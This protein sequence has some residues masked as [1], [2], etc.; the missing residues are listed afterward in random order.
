MAFGCSD[1]SSGTGGSGG[2]GGDGGGGDGGGGGG[3]DPLCE[4]VAGK[5]MGGETDAITEC[6]QVDAAVCTLG[7]PPAVADACAPDASTD[8]PNSCMSGGSTITYALTLMQVAEDCDK[9]F[10]LDDCN[11]DSCA[12]PVPSI[13]DPAPDGADGVDNALSSL[14]PSLVPLDASLTNVN[15]A[16]YDS[17]CGRTN[18]P[19]VGVCEGGTQ[20]T[21]QCSL[22]KACNDVGGAACM[23]D[24]DCTAP[25]KCVDVSD[26]GCAD[27][28][29]MVCADDNSACTTDAD[30]TSPAKCVADKGTC[31][32]K[33]DDCLVPIPA[34]VITFEVDANSA[35]NCANVTVRSIGACSDSG[36]C[37]TTNATA[38]TSIID[39]PAGEICVNTTACDADTGGMGCTAPATCEGGGTTTSI[40]NLSAENTDGTSCLS[41]ELEPIPTL[42]LT[43]PATL[44]NPSVR[45][46]LSSGGFSNGVLGATI[47]EATAKLIAASISEAAVQ[48]I[49]FAFD[50]SDML[51]QDTSAACNALSM[52]LEIGGVTEP[53]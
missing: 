27:G 20:A 51:T 49:P 42:L 25:A 52:G 18:S 4:P 48:V 35:S 21:E 19:A 14:Q 11:G 22:A 28:S 12:R 13:P 53:Q 30:C 40:L 2:A 17:L 37:S 36:I 34:A 33:D 7:Q 26:E 43:V 50:I 46:T 47:D 38:C 23:A 15:Q 39:C 24:T 9:G 29:G 3:I 8:N 5:C 32:L 31:N 44:G 45:M 6:P 10:N 16:F 41:G 1:E